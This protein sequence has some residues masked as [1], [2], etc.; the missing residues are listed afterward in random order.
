[1]TAAIAFGCAVVQRDVMVPMR[2]GVRLA[3]DLY[4]PSDDGVTA[5]NRQFAT[6]LSRTP[7]S[8]TRAGMNGRAGP[9]DQALRAARQG[10]AVAIQDTRGRY[11]SEGSFHSMQNDGP[12]GWDTLV[13]L[14]QQPWCNGRIGT[15][16]GSIPSSA[17]RSTSTKAPPR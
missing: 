14:G 15:A 1:M 3:T 8:K 9:E 5:A 17:T 12:D 11:Q 4:L 7:Y 2:D 6:L 16:G 10:F 13:W